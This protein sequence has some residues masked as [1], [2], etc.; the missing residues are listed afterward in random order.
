MPWLLGC[1]MFTLNILI[2]FPWL[3]GCCFFTLNILILFPWL[4]GRCFF[5]LNILILYAM[6]IWMLHFH[7]IF[8]HVCS[9][10]SG[11]L[12][13]FIW[14][15]AGLSAIAGEHCATGMLLMCLFRRLNSFNINTC[16]WYNKSLCCWVMFKQYSGNYIWKFITLLSS[17]AQYPELVIRK[18]IVLTGRLNYSLQVLTNQCVCSVSGQVPINVP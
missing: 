15:S 13:K 12:A 3:P 2:L 9:T 16:V 18:L 4:P 8:L 10:T 14:E 1:C 7:S 17:C 5:T 6:I 11:L